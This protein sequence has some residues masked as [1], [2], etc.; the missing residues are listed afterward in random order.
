MKFTLSWLKEHLETNASLDE[1]V[2]TMVAVGLEVE[3][4]ENPEER[5]SAFTIGEVLS[6]E[7]HP[8]ADKLQVCKVATRDGEM[9][10]VCGAPNARAG[11]KVAYAPVG[12]YVP[13]IDVTLSKAKIR[14][15]ESHGMMCSVRELE[16][17]DDH[18]GIIEAPVSA[19]V[20]EPVAKVMGANDPVI[21]FEVTPNRPDTNGVDGVARDLAAAGIGKFISPEPKPVKGA[22][23]S[24][25]NVVLDFPAGAENAC[26]VFAFA[27]SAPSSISPTICHTTGRAHCTSSTPTS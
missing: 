7:P 25:Q 6:A 18:D 12:A 21:D 15:V 17:G 2:E 20:G 10:I 13:G 27:P 11:I 23:P 24:P 4:V 19:K 16:L 3:E 8:D 26:P 5:L 22:F 9:Q 14:G 1:I